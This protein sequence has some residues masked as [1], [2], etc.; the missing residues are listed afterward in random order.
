[1]SDSTY[2]QERAQQFVTIVVDRDKLL[3]QAVTMRIELE[4]TYGKR[5]VDDA[6]AQAWGADCPCG[7]TG[8][9]KT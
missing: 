4:R 9:L 2:L 5:A 7:R 6:I 8:E 1:M 3:S